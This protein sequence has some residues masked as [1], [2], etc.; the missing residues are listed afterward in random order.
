[1]SNWLLFV[2]GIALFFSLG[3]IL[4]RR[5]SKSIGALLDRESER[6]GGKVV[7]SFFSS[8]KLLFDY[9][10]VQFA[11]SVLPGG[12]VR[13]PR[14][15]RLYVHVKCPWLMG[16]NFRIKTK[17]NSIQNTID[18]AVN[19]DGIKVSY[20]DFNR[21]FLTYGDRDFLNEIITDDI[22]NDL[23]KYGSPGVD[24]KV[25]V[26]SLVVSKDGAGK[27]PEDFDAITETA[28]R[29]FDVLKSKCL[30]PK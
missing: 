25:M 13:S 6:V 15:E 20:P 14:P 29:F 17:E 8:P 5:D 23:T 19:L 12:G 26:T 1:M 3:F 28:I 7:Y 2:C 9:E 16:V 22:F 10:G 30:L 18:K 21:H 24:V 4:H 11:V 27:T